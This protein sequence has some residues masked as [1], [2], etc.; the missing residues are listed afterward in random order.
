MAEHYIKGVTGSG[1]AAAVPKELKAF[2]AEFK[3][4][5]KRWLKEPH[6]ITAE[7][8]WAFKSDWS[9]T[10]WNDWAGCWVRIKLDV[11]HLPDDKTVV[12]TDWKT[13]KYRPNDVDKYLMQLELYALGAL[14]TYPK[15]ERVI[16]RLG[17]L[18]AGTWHPTDEDK[19]IV[20]T[21]ADLPKLKAVWEKRTKAMLTDRRF[22][23]RPNA[24]C[25]WCHYRA[26]NKANGG[27]QCK[28]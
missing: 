19:A 28:F 7:D 11:A 16:P 24:F 4:M 9:P 14:L 5:R 13:G 2:A 6:T 17:Y 3:A 23:P 26:A 1:P 20:Y 12:V 15:A 18:D 10:T 8:T 21:R 27:G 25:G 22:A